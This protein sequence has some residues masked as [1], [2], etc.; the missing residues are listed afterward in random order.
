MDYKILYDYGT[1]NILKIQ[2]RW[3]EVNDKNAID[4]VSLLQ[5]F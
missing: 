2:N 3:H 5:S 1:E 4:V